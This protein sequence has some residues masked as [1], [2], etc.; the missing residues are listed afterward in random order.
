MRFTFDK[1]T[2]IKEIS[3]EDAAKTFINLSQA[4]GLF[5][6]RKI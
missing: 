3:P 2:M 1:D 5:V 6:N 4:P